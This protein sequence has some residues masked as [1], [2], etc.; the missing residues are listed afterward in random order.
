MALVTIR[1]VHT[2]QLSP[3]LS[4][5]INRLIE[6]LGEGV[7]VS[8]LQTKVDELEGKTAELRTAVDRNTPT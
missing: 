1:V 2:I 4:A 3:E 7:D 5:Q 6:V 8:V